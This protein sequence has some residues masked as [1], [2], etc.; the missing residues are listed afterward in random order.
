VE[1]TIVLFSEME[2]MK[3][4]VPLLDLIETDLFDGV[5]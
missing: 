4:I 1:K 5:G 3:S 2:N